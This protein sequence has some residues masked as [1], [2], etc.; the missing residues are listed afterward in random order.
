MKKFFLLFLL[1][2]HFNA[3]HTYA[4]NAGEN[5]K[6][7]VGLV[8]DQMRWDYLYRFGANYGNDGFKRLLNNGYS[9]EN[10]FIPYLPTYTA[11]GH[12]SVYTGSVPAIHGI[13]GIIGMNAAWAKKFIA[14]MIQP[15]LPLAPV[16]GREK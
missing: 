9:F 5:P 11:V 16:P 10:T 4:Q 13:M 12:T 14:R 2:F 3:F 7:V 15:Y 6:L 1:A 8:I